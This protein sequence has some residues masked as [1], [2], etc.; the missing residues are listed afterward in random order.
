MISRWFH[1]RLPRVL[2]VMLV[3]N[4]ARFLDLHLRHH[5]ALG[6]E[7]AWIFFD[8]STD[9]SR[10]LA[11]AYPWTRSFAVDPAQSVRFPYIADLQRACMDWSVREARALGFDWVLAIDPDEFIDPGAGAGPGPWLPRRLAR[12]SKKTWMVRFD[13][14]EAVP[15]GGP[16][17]WHATHRWFLTRPGWSRP[18][19]HPK[20][21]LTLSWRN[22]LGHNQGKA[23]L[24]TDAPGQA[25]D[26]HRWTS[27][28]WACLPGRPD[29]TPIPT[30]TLGILR[31]YPVTG[32]AH[33]LEKYR[34]FQREPEVWICQKPVEPPKQWWKELAAA[35]TTEEASAYYD[36]HL[37]LA[38]ETLE[39]GVRAGFIEHCPRFADHLE[40][41]AKAA[42]PPAPSPL[43][44]RVP[45]DFPSH[46]TGHP[47]W[48]PREPWDW[49]PS[50]LPL[51][52]LRGFHSLELAGT[53]PF[54]WAG[55]G[56][57]LRLRLPPGRYQGILETGGL[58]PASSLSSTHLHPDNPAWRISPVRHRKTALHFELVAGGEEECWLRIE[59]P[60]FPLPGAE[61]RSLRLPVCSL[62]LH[63]ADRGPGDQTG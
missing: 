55:P 15:R 50:R 26:A 19:V 41:L 18:L 11:A 56:A 29:F 37:V 47:P 17:P 6:V 44:P 46:L 53:R 59:A 61:T 62:L 23:A 35:F 32:A 57:A 14:R 1:R 45:A 22:F 36:R 38:E 7:A 9:G 10:A 3:K 33:W 2:M 5:H 34:S 24:R 51:G 52:D 21:N 40:R 20:K 60:A 31:H 30:E 28:Q 13:I 42:A 54:R 48:E 4:E 12:V 16:G 58:A 63:P 25:Y 49:S 43:P 8:E 27:A 39:D